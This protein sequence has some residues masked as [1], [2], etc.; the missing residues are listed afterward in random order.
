MGYPEQHRGRSDANIVVAVLVHLVGGLIWLGGLYAA[1]AEGF[2]AKIAVV[3][4]LSGA[5]LWARS[6]WRM[7]RARANP[8]RVWMVLGRWYL[9]ALVAPVVLVIAAILWFGEGEGAGVRREGSSTGDMHGA[10]PVL[11]DRLARIERRLH[12]V[13]SELH[14]LKSPAPAPA[15]G[16]EPVREMGQLRIE[17]QRVPAPP[18][19]PR[20]VEPPAPRPRIPAPPPKPA[21]PSFWDRDVALGDL[22]GARA[23]AWAGGIVT[24][25]G[26]VL[27]FALAVNRGWIGPAARVGI[28]ALA[29]LVVFGGGVW[30][31][32]RYGTTYAALAAVGAGIAGG[33]ATL[34]SAASLYD[35]VPSLAA[36]TTAG[37]I[38]AVGLITS[39]VWSSQIV[40]GIGLIGAMLVPI[41]VV[42]DGGLTVLGTTFV[43]FVLAATGIVGVVRRWLILLM[44]AVLASLPQI[45][46]VVVQASNGSARVTALAA[47]FAL[48]YAGIGVALQLRR[49]R[50]GLDGVAASFVIGGALVAG[51]ASLL[52][53]DG[54]PEGVALLAAAASFALG[55]VFFFPATREREL[56]AFLAV[57]ALAL[58][59]VAVADLLSGPVLAIAWAAEAAVLAWLAE[60]T[61]ERRFQVAAF[62]Y[63]ALATV[64][65]LVLDAP[66]RQLFVA[67]A[68]PAAG[69]VA[70]VAAAGAAA[71]VALCA[72]PWPSER[73]TA[74]GFALVEDALASL[75]D[76]QNEIRT[77]VAGVAGLLAMYAASLGVLE[78]FV[79]SGAS[80]TGSFEWGH[81]AVTGIYGV[82][83]LALLLVG[84]RRPAR[85]LE[86]GALAWFAV[87]LAKVCAYDL[88][89]LR[90]SPRS[91]ASLAVAAIAL[92]LA[93]SYQLLKPEL[94]ELRAITVVAEL[95]SA[96]LAVSA[97]I[98]LVGG[99]GLGGD[100][101][102]AALLGLAAVYG[103]TSAV[104]FGRHRDLCTLLW[105][106][107]LA[108]AMAGSID[109]LAG[110]WLV[111]ACVGAATAL[112]AL[113]SRA[114]EP[115]LLLGSL[116]LLALAFA[117]GLVFE[118]PPT[119]L[120]L[121]S[122][123]PGDGVPALL[124]VVIA[125]AAISFFA[126]RTELEE[127][128]L[129]D[130]VGRHGAWLVGAVSVYAGSLGILEVA[131][132]FG[133][134]GVAQDFQH[135]HTAVSVFWG[136][137]GLV[138]LYVGL[139][140]RSR[141]LRLGGFGLFGVSLAK[142]F[143]YDLSAL[144]SITRALSF[145]A[146]GA[147]LLLGGFFY[148][149]LSAEL[150]DRTVG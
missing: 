73:K 116:A 62:T 132:T 147:V 56:S 106:T 19:P 115:R 72:R 23:L 89:A 90:E 105:A 36:L 88:P 70:V 80:E 79:A 20:A 45:A 121:A 149:R 67:S 14:R 145:L 21:E 47:A 25:L 92:A 57:L 109:L 133:I 114:A 76:A 146:V 33:Y 85:T 66:L 93:L 140:R 91:Y 32:H 37:A 97:A 83:A 95:L 41:A 68:H 50:L 42:F 120:F 117:H 1:L 134:S 86:L 130:E 126:G 38:A 60:R 110:T 48:I 6:V 5:A 17:E 40:A 138:A 15:T 75:A 84:L 129:L 63:L 127:L 71:V 113:G 44:I 28:G 69:T 124:L 30:L 8:L 64:H 119:D 101:E 51:A 34:L 35:L 137:L 22:L 29:S 77:A 143:V 144:S 98:V 100:A 26:I 148:Q 87:V 16:P 24:L 141:A 82:V 136:L 2:G 7:D 53:Y 112:A 59:A 125:T 99:D 122:R 46:A 65:T 4:V 139:R 131:E 58:G 74:C 61:Q 135:G 11:A 55:A 102:G 94:E 103:L 81:V 3:W 49:E 108:V 10:D 13:E 150:E 104:V 96:A 142:I 12:A 54:G 43:A 18:E 39:L 52:L 9:E 31:Q 128:P 27:L 107:A 111:L 78:L 118:A 123:H